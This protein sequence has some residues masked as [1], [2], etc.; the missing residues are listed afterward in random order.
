MAANKPFP[1]VEAVPM[2]P[3]GSEWQVVIDNAHT[4]VHTWRTYAEKLT[5]AE[6]RYVAAAINHF[7]ALRGSLQERTSFACKEACDQHD[8]AEGHNPGCVAAVTVLAEAH[9]DAE[10]AG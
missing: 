2:E 6:A 1:R 10:D 9:G 7:G 5:E 8:D 4:P 3:G